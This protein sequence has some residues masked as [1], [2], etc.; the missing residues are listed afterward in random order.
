M[1]PEDLGHDAVQA[2]CPVLGRDLSDNVPWGRRNIRLQRAGCGA[3]ADY[4]PEDSSK[5]VNVDRSPLTG[6]EGENVDRAIVEVG[7]PSLT[8]SGS[9]LH[10]RMRKGLNA[11]YR[12][13]LRGVFLYGSRAR[14][15][16]VPDSDVDVLIVLDRVG[17]YGEE[18]ERTSKLASDLSIEAG[19]IVNRTFASEADWQTGAKPFLVSAR[20]DALH[21]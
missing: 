3:A 9:L 19:V 17:R 11:I 2:G 1:T 7:D 13:R 10:A 5:L 18:L 6:R 15:E 4:G 14:G 16:H 8:Q 12:K 21:V 20:A